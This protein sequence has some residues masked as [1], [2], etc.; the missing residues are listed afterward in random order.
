MRDPRSLTPRQ[1]E[2]LDRVAL[3]KPNRQIADELGIS[4]RAVKALVTRLFGKLGVQNRAALIATVLRAGAG[5]GLTADSTGDFGQYLDAPFMITVLRGA[6]HE[7]AFVNRMFVQVSGVA[8]ADLLGRELDEAFPDAEIGEH[9]LYEAVL[10]TGIPGVLA[11]SPSRWRDARGE[12]RS[13]VFHTLVHP[14][15]GTSGS[16]DALLTVTTAVEHTDQR[17]V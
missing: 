16:V 5:G 12:I 11:G 7:F 8:A 1:Q 15:R 4:E 17:T 9:P 14:L 10:A 13:G 2:V 6:R 3:G